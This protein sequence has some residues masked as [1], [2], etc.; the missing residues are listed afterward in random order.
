[1]PPESSPP[2]SEQRAERHR[3]VDRRYRPLSD[4]EA[5]ALI[6]SDLVARLAAALRHPQI[7]QRGA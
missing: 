1:M 3:A 2:S 7:T 5:E 6:G 4:H